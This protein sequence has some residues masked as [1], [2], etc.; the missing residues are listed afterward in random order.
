[1]SLMGTPLKGSLLVISKSVPT[2]EKD[3]VL[4]GSV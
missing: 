1:M 3:Q 4:P 2:L